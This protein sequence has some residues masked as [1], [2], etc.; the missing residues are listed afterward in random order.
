MKIKVLLECEVD[1]GLEGEEFYDVSQ[2]IQEDYSGEDI[3]EEADKVT[4]YGI[5]EMK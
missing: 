3:M 2:R 5:R 1:I 4:I